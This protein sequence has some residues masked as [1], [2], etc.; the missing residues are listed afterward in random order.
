MRWDVI[1]EAMRLARHSLGDDAWVDVPPRLVG[2]GEVGVYLLSDPSK[3]IPCMKYEV[4]GWGNNPR[5]ML[6]LDGVQGVVRLARTKTSS[7]KTSGR[8]VPPGEAAL[9]RY[10]RRA[11]P[12][13][14]EVAVSAGNFDE[15]VR[16]NGVPADAA[17]LI[18]VILT[19]MEES[20]IT[21]ATKKETKVAWGPASKPKFM[22]STEVRIEVGSYRKQIGWIVDKPRKIKGSFWYLVLPNG[23]AEPIEYPEDVLSPNLVGRLEEGV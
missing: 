2:R 18:R 17:E 4:R 16:D 7:F 15:W 13:L 12:L 1:K 5:V 8:R 10:G 21:A 23:S 6:E 11:V 3:T 9:M 19:S 22:R 20:R 14:A